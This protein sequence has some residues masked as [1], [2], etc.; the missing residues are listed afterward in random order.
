MFYIMFNYVVKF[1]IFKQKTKFRHFFRLKKL[2]LETFGTVVYRCRILMPKHIYHICRN[3]LFFF[4]PCL[5][6][7]IELHLTLFLC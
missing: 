2:N 6:Y 4:L 7:Y 5:N 3:C 1:E